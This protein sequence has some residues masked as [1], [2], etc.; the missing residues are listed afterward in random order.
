MAKCPSGTERRSESFVLLRDFGGKKTSQGSPIGV[1][2]LIAE[3]SSHMRMHT[4][5]LFQ[6]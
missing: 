5:A 4:S 2:T 3:E 1:V 6:I